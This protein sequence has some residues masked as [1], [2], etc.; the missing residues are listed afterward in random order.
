[1]PS[2]KRWG[3]GIQVSTTLKGGD[4]LLRKLKGLGVDATKVSD[5]ATRE[6]MG[7]AHGKIEADAPGP[8]IVMEPDKS[9]APG[10][11]VYVVGPDKDHWY[12][13]FFETG[14]SAFEINM[15][16]RRTKRTA[17]EKK[18]GKAMRG[19]K[20]RSEGNVLAFEASGGVGGAVVFAKRVQRGPM[21]AQPF[22][23]KNFLGSENPMKDKFGYVISKAVITKYLERV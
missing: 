5:D 9:P 18:T 1:M 19:R 20:V 2:S 22:M 15:V 4:E 11:A 16:K 17:T 12:Y 8:G 10:V 21:A 23:R 6:A 13:Q 14:V 7:V 3:K